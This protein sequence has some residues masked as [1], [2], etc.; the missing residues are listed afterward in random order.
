MS[1]D[2][3]Y[4]QSISS[5]VQSLMER[6]QSLTDG[7]TTGNRASHEQCI[8]L[9]EVKESLVREH[10]GS[11]TKNYTKSVKILTDFYGVSRQS[12]NYDARIGELEKKVS[13][14]EPK[15]EET[16]GKLDKTNRELNNTR[17]RVTWLEAYKEEKGDPALRIART[18][19]DILEEMDVNPD[20][21]AQ[22]Y[23]FT[24]P[25]LR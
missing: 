12:L 23:Q 18:W 19:Q 6:Y 4:S 11:N 7:V 9:S 3:I 17:N 25:S 16:T 13:E 14:I 24:W 22:K 8:I 10:G 2:R 20:K 21:I 15:L 5:S 1:S